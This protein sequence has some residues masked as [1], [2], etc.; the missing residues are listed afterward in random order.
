MCD[1][2]QQLVENKMKKIDK[3]MDNDLLVILTK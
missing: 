1:T 2:S 3:N